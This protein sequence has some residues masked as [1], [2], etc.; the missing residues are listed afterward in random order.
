M[1]RAVSCF[2]IPG[3]SC[4]R[5][6][7][8]L[9]IAPTLSRLLGAVAPNTDAGTMAGKP[10]ATRAEPPFL[11]AAAANSLRRDISFRRLSVMAPSPARVAYGH[12]PPS[13]S[14]HE[15]LFL[16]RP[17]ARAAV[18]ESDGQQLADATL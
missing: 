4:P 7:R 8:P 9:P 17:T 11:S 5:E 18:G 15:D 14:C 16:A 13:Q 12:P 3:M 2:Q 6:I 10:A 1:I